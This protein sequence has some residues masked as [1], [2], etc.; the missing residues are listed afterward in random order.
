MELPITV[1][2]TRPIEV[3]GKTW[4][5]LSFDEPDLD[6]EIAFMEMQEG[7]PDEPSEADLTKITRF[8]LATLSGMP[9]KV[10]GKIKSADRSAVIKAMDQ[11]FDQV[12]ARDKS[13]GND[14]AAA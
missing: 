2:L 5:E 10:I 1:P 4:S 9:E 6:A 13:S 8:W 3:D 12:K 11:V 14:E 7:L